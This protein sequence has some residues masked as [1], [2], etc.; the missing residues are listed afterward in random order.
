MPAQTAQTKQMIYMIYHSNG[1]QYELRLEASSTRFEVCHAIMS[2]H[3]S[4]EEVIVLIVLR[5]D[6]VVPMRRAVALRWRRAPLLF[7]TQ[8]FYSCSEVCVLQTQPE[9]FL[10]TTGTVST[11]STGHVPFSLLLSKS[12]YSN[13]VAESSCSQKIPQS[14]RFERA[15]PEGAESGRPT[16]EGHGISHCEETDSWAFK[17]NVRSRQPR[18]HLYEDSGGNAMVQRLSDR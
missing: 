15:L 13:R 3:A 1:V 4:V 8:L 10:S 6:G 14:F 17:Y 18:V 11:F 2:A 16:R 9:H 5:V 12:F 7:G